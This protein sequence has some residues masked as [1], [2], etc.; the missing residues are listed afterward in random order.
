M[1]KYLDITFSL[2]CAFIVPYIG[3]SQVYEEAIGNI[4]DEKIKLQKSAALTYLAF[5]RSGIRV[6]FPN[7][8]ISGLILFNCN[9][10][11]P[12][13]NQI[14]LKFLFY[15]LNHKLT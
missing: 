8:V 1:N 13:K 9:N 11:D 3:F 10:Y 6:G 7:N 12:R 14:G 15:K 2:Q 5:E 4:I